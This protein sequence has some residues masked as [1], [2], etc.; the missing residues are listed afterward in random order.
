[1]TSV[2]ENQKVR[3]LVVDDSAL[4]RQ[5]LTKILSADPGIDVVGIAHDP[6]FAREKIEKLRPDVL[7]LD[8]EMPRMDGLTFLAN[9]MKEHPMP[10]VMISSLTQKGCETTLRALELGAVDFFPKPSLDTKD[11]MAA[12]AAEIIQKVKTAAKVQIRQKTAAVK[13]ATPLRIEGMSPVQGRGDGKIIAIGA[14]TGGTEAIREVLEPLPEDLPGIVIVQ[15]MPP[16]FTNSFA[17][18]LDGV[19]A[20]NV[21]EAVDGDAVLPGHAL[22]APGDF[23]MQVVRAGGLYRVRIAKDPPVNL[24]RPSVDYLF[25]SVAECAGIGAIG[26]IL[27]G[28][29]ADGARGM[30]RMWENQARTIAQDEGSCVVYGMPKEA[31]AHGGAE[32]VL[33]LSAI[34]SKLVSLV[35]ESG[36]RKPAA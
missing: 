35:R 1:M 14:S 23:Q 7:T 24:H 18:R 25:D 30:R 26:V 31:V 17:K 27:T 5:V 33:P 8:I 28:M 15:H 11:A 22:V 3:V 2:S 9:L 10:V 36:V 19:C 29:G 12:A 6:L 34:A 20:L 13:P 4:I 32:F 21:K 16:G